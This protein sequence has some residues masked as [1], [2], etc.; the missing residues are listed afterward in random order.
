MAGCPPA[1]LPGVGLLSPAAASPRHVPPARP[2]AAGGASGLPQVPPAR[3]GGQGPRGAAGSPRPRRAERARPARSRLASRPRSAPARGRCP[4]PAPLRARGSAP[5][6]AALLRAPGP[7]Q[8]NVQRGSVLSAAPHWLLRH[9]PMGVRAAHWPGA[10][11]NQRAAECVRAGGGGGGGGGEGGSGGPFP[12]CGW[13]RLRLRGRCGRRGAAQGGLA[14][15]RPP[16]LAP[17]LAR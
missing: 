5:R 7:R 16:G 12:A 17:S 4:L 14:A 11:V 6:F 8:P 2:R 1:C 9:S 13:R 15:S 3:G 10:A